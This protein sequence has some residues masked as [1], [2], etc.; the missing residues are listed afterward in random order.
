MYHN[1][2]IFAEMSVYKHTKEECP[3]DYVVGIDF[4]KPLWQQLQAHPTPTSH[5]FRFPSSMTPEE[6]EWRMRMF[7]ESM[8][9]VR[10]T[11]E[12]YLQSSVRWGLNMVENWP[13]LSQ[14]PLIDNYKHTY[15][16]AVIVGAG[17]STIPTVIRLKNSLEDALVI[18]CFHIGPQLYE[19]IGEIDLMAHIDMVSLHSD[20]EPH[21]IAKDVVVAP[22]AGPTCLKWHHGTAYN[23]FSAGDPFSLDGASKFGVHPHPITF[24]NVGHMMINVAGVLGIQQIELVGIDLAY[25]NPRVNAK[26][27][28]NKHKKVCFTDNMMDTYRL[29]FEDFAQR[30]PNL[31]L[32]NHSKIGQDIYGWQAP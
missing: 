20:K 27:I 1:H 26:R 9:Q 19:I 14:S 32:I 12:A 8:I 25:E 5:S 21:P 30:N 18:G 28:V 15:T 23:Y 31:T 17:P 4:T 11:R 24:G 3:D 10:I 7:E 29:G 13:T 2:I 6:V 22:N 16:R